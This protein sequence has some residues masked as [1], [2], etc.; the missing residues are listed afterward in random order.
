MYGLYLVNSDLVSPNPLIAVSMNGKDWLECNTYLQATFLAAMESIKGLG[1]SWSK[2]D[3]YKEQLVSLL[4]FIKFH[5][6]IYGDL[7][8]G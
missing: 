8:E 5:N 7:D 1:L 6:H 2:A 3:P 4:S